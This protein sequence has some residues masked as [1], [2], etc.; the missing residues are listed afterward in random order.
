MT[1][2]DKRDDAMA[3]DGP[4]GS[5]NAGPGPGQPYPGGE[6]AGVATGQPYPGGA[7][8]QEEAG[9]AEEH[10]RRRVIGTPPPATARRLL[11]PE[12][13]DGA[14]T[15]RELPAE[16]ADPRRAKRAERVVALFFTLSFLGSAGFI[17]SYV[18]FQV[19]TVNRT[20]ASNLGLGI[21]MSVAF[22]ALAAGAVVWVRN[23]MPVVELTE[24]RKPL[25]SP[26]PDR[27]AF[28]E[29]FTEGTEASQFV[30]RPIIRRTLLAAIAPLTL[31]PL[32]L[33]RD[34]G[35][36]PRQA[37]R[38][39]AWK[40][41]S[42]LVVMG[43]NAPLRP[44]DLSPGS[45]ITVIPE[46]IADNQD[47]LAKAAVIIIKFRP[48]E[49]FSPTRMD[50]TVEGI[51]AYSKICTHVGCP[52]ALFEHTTNHILCPCHQ[53]TFNAPRGAEVIFGPAP[54]PLP[55]L[56]ITTNSQGYLVAQSD[57]HEPV[58]PSFW[59]LG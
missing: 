8:T 22:L 10:G 6:E 9:T 51:V 32:V 20:T 17:A 35:P 58:G 15:P 53:S 16:P 21:S 54:R 1:D 56:P 18:I 41:G 39:T 37:L 48:E 26:E 40:A 44:G 2:N 33:L 38:H 14:V 5:G 55:Q 34:M 59:E 36:L 49:L 42:R 29:T 19:H 52:A 43:T 45:L 46:G 3:T 4:Q 12:P 23:V 57:F 28:T 31:A 47:E 25:R 24:A 13:P 30:K 50:W 11:A 7:A 27:K